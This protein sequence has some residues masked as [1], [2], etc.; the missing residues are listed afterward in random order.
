MLFVEKEL[1]CKVI[2][3]RVL[4]HHENGFAYSISG[5]FWSLIHA[6]LTFPSFII[7]HEIVIVLAFLV[8]DS[9]N[10]FQF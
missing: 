5:Y 4:Q 1:K 6:V 8:I 10:S 3:F 2:T 9:I 7:E